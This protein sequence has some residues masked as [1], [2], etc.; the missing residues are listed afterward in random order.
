MSALRSVP[1]GALV[2]CLESRNYLT[3]NTAGTLDG[4]FGNG[5]KV[6]PASNDDYA[7]C[8]TTQADGKYVVAGRSTGTVDYGMAVARYMPDG[9]LDPTFGDGGRAMVP[10]DS[11]SYVSGVAIAADG[12]IVL[13][14][15]TDLDFLVVRLNANGSLDNS[16]SGDGRLQTDFAGQT[17][18]PFALALRS[19][20]KIL[21][22]GYTF[23]PGTDV[24]FALL[25][26]NADG[27]VDQS[28]GA[29]GKSILAASRRRDEIHQLA[30]L[31]D[32][33]II[34]S[35]ITS[36]S[37][38]I[39]RLTANGQ[40]DT[41]FGKG[42]VAAIGLLGQ[43]GALQPMNDG[44]ILVAGPDKGKFAALRL[45]AN[46][47]VDQTFGVGGMTSVEFGYNDEIVSGILVQKGGKIVLTGS[48]GDLRP[49]Y[50]DQRADF[51]LTRLSAAGQLDQTFGEGGRAMAS[52]YRSADI[53]TASALLAKGR[54]VVVGGHNFDVG[55]PI[56][57]FQLAQF[58]VDGQL[59]T[60]TVGG[61]KVM[62][63]FTSTATT[64][65]V[66]NAALADGGQL[67]LAS[68]SDNTGERFA[69]T[70]YRADGS[71]ETS[72]GPDNKGTVYV[73]F[74]GGLNYA[75]C[76]A[77]KA[78][79]TIAVAG[80]ATGGDVT[81][82]VA[83]ALFDADGNPIDSFGNHGQT[84]EV[85]PN[86]PSTRIFQVNAI[87]FQGSKLVVAGGASSNV[88]LL[89]RYN[90]D[91]TFDQSFGDGGV[92]TT[93]FTPSPFGDI[94]TYAND[95]AIQDDGKIVVVGSDSKF[96]D[97]GISPEGAF[98]IAR[99]NTDGTLDGTFGTG[100]KVTVSIGASR[101][102][103][104]A[105]SVALQGNGRI[106]VAGISAP[107]QQSTGPALGDMAVIRLNANGTLD[108]SFG[109][110]GKVTVDFGPYRDAANKVLVQSDGKIILAG[111][112][113][114]DIASGGGTN[115]DFAL[116]RLN[117]D[118][119]P[120]ST[121]GTGG[122]ATA[123]FGVN[124]SIADIALDGN[125]QI[126]AAGSSDSH[127]AL[128]RFLNDAV[129]ITYEVVNDTLII[130]GTP[131]D[132]QIILGRDFDGPVT[133]LGTGF[134]S[135]T[136]PFSKVQIN[137]L[138]GNDRLDAGL[139]ADVAG[140]MHGKVYAPVTIDGGTGD[141]FIVGGPANDSLLGGNGDDTIVGG[142]GDDTVFAGSGDDVIHGN[143]G[144]DYLSGGAGADHIFADDGNDQIYASDGAIDTIDGGLGFDRINGDQNDVQTS[145]EGVLP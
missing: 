90:A 2:E 40:F 4:S 69:L 52:F 48:V 37:W 81:P 116:A 88:F 132:D 62:T 22:G 44:T 27:T 98:V 101:I 117:S 113:Q 6:L 105:Y 134:N 29:G 5:G 121:F 127:T 16:F 34:A 75:T 122:K 30:F 119:T 57:D 49:Q 12:K 51:A 28:F 31:P 138:G 77:M 50:P 100:G 96:V 64:A 107:V 131:G 104:S 95:L 135:M 54:I 89:L 97:F 66:A 93:E 17:D 129:G 42:G 41:S 114:T 55:F 144:N 80:N 125:G 58:T 43:V 63:D 3:A 21:V 84:S 126:L 76:M 123:N 145:I 61:G 10:F 26:L 140:L 38:A 74:G 68:Y 47:R 35:G 92:V 15:G 118:G 94:R 46:G 18:N 45:L 60:T 59:D 110:G 91:G 111:S 19:D 8:V 82:S 25:Q 85:P 124:D 120:D 71:I 99:Y 78:D 36:T 137:G 39:S 32:G 109:A 67:V 133:I 143:E 23:N 112:T 1:S 106:V 108:Q 115:V 56:I 14:A 70:R 136:Q 72:F 33:R 65:A 24:D 139:L 141:D 87:K 53:A 83:V 102:N 11:P 79:G 142:E 7:Q 9:S 86:N 103:D 73:D 130:I 13:A 20:G 128:A